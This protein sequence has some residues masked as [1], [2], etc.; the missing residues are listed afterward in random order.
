MLTC[1][2]L[3]H[4]LEL[5]ISSKITDKMADFM[6]TI[7][8]TV[9][10]KATFQT[11]RIGTS[12]TDWAQL[13]RLFTRGRNQSSFSETL[14]HIKQGPRIMSKKAIIILIFHHHELLDLKKTDKLDLPHLSQ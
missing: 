8:R 12:S 7:H 2:M 11:L 5:T 9:F 14:F 4:C 13:S 6:D 1:Y 3:I 10:I